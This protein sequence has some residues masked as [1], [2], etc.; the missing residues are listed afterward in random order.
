MDSVCLSLLL[1]SI[2]LF[3]SSFI[4]ISVIIL[5]LVCY[6][7]LLFFFYRLFLY[8]IHCC[9]PLICS[10]ICSIVLCIIC[11][12]FLLSSLIRSV[13]Q[14]FISFSICRSISKIRNDVDLW[15]EDIILTPLTLLWHVHSLLHTWGTG[16]SCN[17]QS[18][19]H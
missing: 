17:T 4:V 8:S 16:G 7:Y 13:I 14:S 3:Y 19:L 12:F 11:Y 1:L 6:F 2:L 9:H 15:F 10:T 5:S 18:I